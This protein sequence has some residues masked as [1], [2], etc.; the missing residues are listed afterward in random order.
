MTN[1]L[2]RFG[3]PETLQNDYIIF[4]MAARGIN[5][6]DAPP[7]LQEFLRLALKHH[8]INIGNAVKGGIY[9][10]SQNLTPLAHWRRADSV[11]PEKVVE[12]IDT[13]TTVAA[14]F[15]DPKKLEAFLKDL[16]QADLGISINISA[17]TEEA[18]T[19]CQRAGI[20][21]HSVEYS[22]GFHGDLN[23]L[24]DRHVL[25]LSTMCGHGMVSHNFA[26]KMID[27]VKEGRRDPQQ[28]AAC[29]ARFCT[30]G[31]FN[32]VRAEGLLEEARVGK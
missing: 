20:T 10:A 28:A 21:R 23:H 19:C 27:L 12:S 31:I 29:L 22:L 1:T 2:H 8:P 14:V 26:K 6:K 3:A 17:L 11:A 4:A 25:E 30:C 16:R 7:K 5:D 9:R 24:P 13:C 15:D 32:P 18:R